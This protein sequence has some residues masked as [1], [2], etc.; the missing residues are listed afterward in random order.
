[1]KREP[2]YTISQLAREFDLSTRTIRFYEEKGLLAPQRTNGGHRVYFRQDRSRIR[3]ILRGKRF[4]HTLDEIADMIGLA[5][6]SMSEEEQIRKTLA[7]GDRHLQ[8]IQRN[9][10]DLRLMESDIRDLKQRLEKRL[11]GLREAES[12]KLKEEEKLKRE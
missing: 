4:G 10:E 11:A 9:M 8:Q 2:R 1:M 7:Y 5:S 12:S 3:L 6:E